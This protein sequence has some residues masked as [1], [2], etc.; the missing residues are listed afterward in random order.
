MVVGS[1]VGPH[2]TAVNH[3]PDRWAVQRASV[4][5]RRAND[6]VLRRQIALRLDRCREIE[7]AHHL[8]KT[9]SPLPATRG[10]HQA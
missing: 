1:V 8:N 6:H 7:L 10:R 5:V 2:R 4:V 9:D 3:A